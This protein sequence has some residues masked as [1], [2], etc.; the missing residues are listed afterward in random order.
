MGE[1]DIKASEARRKITEETRLYAEEMRGTIDSIGVEGIE[2]SLIDAWPAI[3]AMGKDVSRLHQQ[4]VDDAVES[5]A[6]YDAA[7]QYVYKSAEGYQTDIQK[8]F[9]NSFDRLEDAIVN[10][11]MTGKAN[12]KSFADSAIAS[13]MKIA[14]QSSITA[15]LYGLLGGFFPSI[16]PV[17]AKAAGGPV[18]GGVSYLV[19]E[20]GPE[21]FVP[22][23][24]GTIIPNG[25]G[26]GGS[27]NIKVQVINESGT[28][29]R[30]RDSRVS[31]D[32]QEM[33]V[34]LWMDAVA[35]NRFGVRDLLGGA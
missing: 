32:P 35:R 27:Q 2:E 25:G 7:W 15:P 21:V 29:M 34:T 19:G 12:F 23:T 24:A 22:R 4:M 17:G 13:L 28:P 3:Q 30:V 9:L 11:T 5:A 6:A 8:V 16:F 18:S 14:I 1:E 20:R 26:G 33:V 10:F 31:F